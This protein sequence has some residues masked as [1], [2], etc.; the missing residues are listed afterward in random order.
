MQRS[1]R[2][3]NVDIIGQFIHQYTVT[4]DDGGIHG[5]RGDGI[6]VGD[7]ATK[8]DH[9]QYEQEEPAVFFK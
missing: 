1:L 3:G 2:Q 9:Q 4:F 5:T 6:P 7:G 8:T